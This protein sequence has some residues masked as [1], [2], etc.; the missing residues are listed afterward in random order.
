MKKAI[1][2]AMTV[3][4]FLL[5]TAPALYAGEMDVLVNKLV[6]KGILTTYEGQVLMTQAKEEVAIEK[7][8]KNPVNVSLKE[9]LQFK[10]QD[11]A[12]EMKIGG[13]VH[14]DMLY[15]QGQKT[16]GDRIG[17]DLDHY[18][19]TGFRRAR[20]SLEGKVYDDFFFKTQYDFAG[21][22]VGFRDLYMGMQNIP[23]AGRITVG[24]FKEPMG[25]DTLTSSNNIT[26][27][28]R[29]LPMVF[30]PDRQWGAMVD[31]NWFDQNLTFATGVFKNSNN[32]SGN[33]TSITGNE[34]NWTSRITGTPLFKNVPGEIYKVAHLG[35]SYSLRSPDNN[36][37]RFRERPEMR[38]ED[39]FVDT[40]NFGAH[41]ENRIGTEAALV[42]GPFS[43]QGEFLSSIVDLK[44]NR[45]ATNS[46]FYGAYGYVSYFLTGEN[47][48]YS[49]SSGAFSGVTPKNNFSFK[50]G[51]WGAW[52][53]AARYSYLDLNDKDARINGG[54]LNDMTLGINWYLNRN[55]RMML[56]YVH[57]NRN[58]VGYAD[59]VQGRLQVN[60]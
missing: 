48:N 6:E 27:M 9:G 23:Y 44:N 47:R 21:A 41:M 46:Y 55:F 40:G 28:E 31:N 11:G 56:N 24:Q 37:L 2:K 52:E 25:L 1:M 15:L 5:F 53:I 3:I 7:A 33:L 29:A 34:W 32:E 14:A 16:L 38:T 26:F 18:N 10:T 49:K 4:S 17:R 36:V 19:N 60:F 57:T 45:N 13:R 39:R 30:A 20:L 58:G 59:G 43:V 35:A 8:H 12:F 42:Y 50:D 54:I 51:T 22:A